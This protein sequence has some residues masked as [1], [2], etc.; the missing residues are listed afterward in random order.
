MSR[1][2]KPG[3]EQRCGKVLG[4]LLLD[5]NIVDKGDVGHIDLNKLSLFVN[6]V[7]SITKTRL[8]RFHF[9]KSLISGTRAPPQRAYPLLPIR[10]L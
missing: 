7:T 5:G 2:K 9:P 8:L 6:M 4:V 1:I 3:N 10:R